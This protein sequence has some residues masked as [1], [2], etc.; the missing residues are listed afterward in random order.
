MALKIYAFPMSPRSFKVLW[1]AHHL[2][3]DYDFVFVDFTKGMQR[4]PEYLAINP[5]G[6][7]PVIDD[8]GFV[9]WES[10][11]I[12]DYLASK[13]P[14]SA[15]MPADARAQ[16]AVRKWLFWDS[17]HW[18]EPCESFI[19][20]RLVKPVFEMGPASEFELARAHERF[21]RSAKML[22]A[23]LGKHRYVAGDSLTV[24]D[25]A[26]ASPLIAAKAAGIP[27]APY[28]SINRWFEQL[29][30]LPSWQKT[31]AMQQP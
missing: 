20:E 8:D 11:A 13:K 18:D 3:L 19:F 27:L 14:E 23:E 5:N 21:E 28:D 31:V 24:A 15:L 10:N 6:R 30:A 2:D 9:L 16:Y 7:A 29:P 1:T 22:N 17:C 12:V 4:T 25:L 26:I